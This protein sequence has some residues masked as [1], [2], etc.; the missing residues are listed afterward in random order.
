MEIGG[1]DIT[2]IFLELLSTLGFNPAVDLR[3][4]P[5]ALLIQELKERLCH[6]DHVSA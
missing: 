2:R 5:D 1:S 3:L 4:Y 6:L